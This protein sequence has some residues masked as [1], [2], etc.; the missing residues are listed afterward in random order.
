MAAG[1]T[2]MLVNKLHK[3]KKAAAISTALANKVNAEVDSDTTRLQTLFKDIHE[4]PELGFMQT[5]T[6]DIIAKQVVK[7]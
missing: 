3:P 2:V 4:H 1:P 7:R 5:R 6:A